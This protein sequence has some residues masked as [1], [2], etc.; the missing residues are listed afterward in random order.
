ME[1]L[2]QACNLSIAAIE[3]IC[4]FHKVFQIG[5]IEL[6]KQLHMAQ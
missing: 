6:R 2:R 3:V 1:C 5:L 4:I